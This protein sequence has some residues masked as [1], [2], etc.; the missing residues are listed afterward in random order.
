[1]SLK[2]IQKKLQIIDGKLVL[3]SQAINVASITK[4]F[5]V[6]LVSNQIVLNDATVPS[7]S[8]DEQLLYI[9]G[10]TSLLGLTNVET[11]GFFT[12]SAD[13]PALI[14]IISLPLGWTPE[15][16]FSDIVKNDNFSLFNSISFS[17]ALFILSS[18]D[19]KNSDLNL[20]IEEGLNFIAYTTLDGIFQ[21]L[22][23]LLNISNEIKLEGSIG[24]VIDPNNSNKRLPIFDFTAFTPVQASFG[25]L[26][27]QDISIEFAS[28]A[29]I[30]D[31]ENNGTITQLNLAFLASISG[32]IKIGNIIA[33]ITAAIPLN[34]ESNLEFSTYFEEANIPGLDDIAQLIGGSIQD[35]IPLDLIEIDVIKITNVEICISLQNKEIQYIN[36]E[37]QTTN[38]WIIIPNIF[39]IKN[40]VS[41]WFLFSPTQKK[42]QISG[43]ICGVLEIGS[44]ELQIQADLPLTK[45]RA[46]LVWGQSIKVAKLLQHLIPNL[47]IL[48]S[49]QSLSISQLDLTIQPKYKSY[50]FIAKIDDIWS[51]DLEFTRIGIDSL[52]LSINS[53]PNNFSLLCIGNTTLFNQ[54]CSITIERQISYTNQQIQLSNRWLFKGQIQEISLST[55]VRE[56]F[57][58][59]VD[60]FGLKELIISNLNFEMIHGIEQSYAFQGTLYWDTGISLSENQNIIIQATINIYKIYHQVNQAIKGSIS[61]YISTSIPYFET[62]KL[63]AIYEFSQTHKDL[64]FNLQ[65][66]SLSL[67]FTYTS[68][69]SG[70]TIL[71]LSAASGD[72][73]FGELISSIVSL[74]DPTID[75]FQLDPP[76][77]TL[78]AQ[79]FSLSG[80]SVSL[81]TTKKQFEIEYKNLDLNLGFASIEGIKLIYQQKPTVPGQRSV[82]ITIVGTIL[83]KTYGDENAPSWDA[84]NQPPPA[85]PGRGSTIF[86]LQYLGVGQHV[87]FD[88]ATVAK[89]TTISDVM[90]ALR[91]TIIP[92]ATP[93]EKNQNPLKLARNLQFNPQSGLLIGAQFTI[94][95]TLNMSVIFNDPLLYGVRIVL[96][97]EKAQAFAGLEF[98][99]LYRRISDTIG[100]YHSE[101]VLPTTMRQ[102]EFGAVA[103]TLPIIVI[104]IYTNGDFKL[105]FGFPWNFDFSRSFALSS[106]P[107]TG[108][109]GFYFNKLSAETATNLPTITNGC[110]NPV[111]EFGL[112]LKIGLGKS[113]SKGPLQAEFSITVQGILQGTIAWFNPTDIA[114]PT[115][116]YYRI[117]GGVGIIGRLYGNVDFK[118]IQVTVEVL[119]RATVLFIVEAYQPTQL[120]LAA[121][122]S[123][124]A[125]IKIVFININFSFELK[126]QETFILGSIQPTPWILGQPV[127]P[128]LRAE[129]LAATPAPMAM[130]AM[131]AAVMGILADEIADF[132]LQRPESAR[133]LK[134]T[135]V[136]VWIEAG[137]PIQKRLDLFFQ[138]TVT[139]NTEGISI[140]ALLFIENCITPQSQGP[141]TH[142]QDA[143]ADTKDFDRLIQALLI[144]ALH[145]Y[146]YP[147]SP[148]AE[149]FTFQQVRFLEGELLEDLRKLYDL[150]VKG[151]HDPSAPFNFEQLM[152]FL[153]QNFIFHISDCIQDTSGTIFPMFP[154]LSRA[155]GDQ[156]L[157][158]EN[159]NFTAFENYPSAQSIFMDYFSLLIRGGIQAAIDYL[160]NRDRPDTQLSLGNLLDAL[161]RGGPFNHLA[162]MAS[163]FLLHGSRWSQGNT[164]VPLYAATGQQIPL[165]S[166]DLTAI[167]ALTLSK[168]ETLTEVTF[169]DSRKD[170]DGNRLEIPDSPTLQF[171][172]GNEPHGSDTSHD[173]LTLI[174]QLSTVDISL[175]S[176]VPELMPFYKDVP[177]QFNLQHKTDWTATIAAEDWLAQ[178]APS[179][180][181]NSTVIPI[182]ELPV[183]FQNYLRAKG[184]NGIALTLKQGTT[185]SNR[186]SL[187]TNDISTYTWAT[188]LNLTIQRE[189]DANGNPLPNIYRM[190]GVNAADKNL[191]GALLSHIADRDLATSNLQ[192]YLLES[193]ADDNPHSPNDSDRGLVNKPLNNSL[194]LKT[195]LSTESNPPQP[196]TLQI[197]T[198]N[199]DSIFSAKLSEGKNFL[200]LIWE[201]STVN[202]GG[203]FLN[204]S[205]TGDEQG[206]PPN[207]FVDGRT[208]SLILLIVIPGTSTSNTPI[209]TQTAYPFHNC[210][211]VRNLAINLETETIYAESCETVK[212][213]NI[214]TGHIGFRLEQSPPL[215]PISSSTP[216]PSAA[217]QRQQAEYELRQLYHLLGFELLKDNNSAFEIEKALPIG[218]ANGNSNTPVNENLW[219]Y[220]R[221]IRLYSSQP[222]NTTGL[223]PSADQNPYAGINQ[224]ATVGIEFYWQDIYG[225]RFDT[226]RTPGIPVNYQ[227]FPVRYFDPLLGI[228]QWPSVVA[229]YKFIPI[230]GSASQVS[231]DIELEFNPTVQTLDNIY[232]DSSIYQQVYYQIHQPDVEFI[233]R[234]SIL[235]D[236][237]T[238]IEKQLLINFVTSIY[239][240]LDS[241]KKRLEAGLNTS[242]PPA[243]EA[244]P[245]KL[246][247]SIQLPLFDLTG[248][249]RYPIENPIFPVSV[250]IDI[251]RD[252]DHLG[253]LVYCNNDVPTTAKQVTTY[254][255]PNLSLAT[256]AT[257]EEAED[258]SLRQ[259][260]EAF[261]AAFIRNIDGKGRCGLHLAVGNNPESDPNTPDITN[262]KALWAVHFGKTGI[263]YNINESMPFFFSPAPLSNTLLSGKV[264]LDRYTSGQDL[265]R[266]VEDKQVDSIDLN[267]LA[268]DFLEAVEAF[269]EPAIA[270]PAYN[271]YPEDKDH[272]VTKILKHKQN[273]AEVISKQVT[274]ILEQ[275]DT[276]DISQR[277]N[278]AQET[279][280]QQLLV[281]LV[282]AFDIETIVQYNVDVAVAGNPDWTNDKA[283]CLFGQPVVVSSTR[284]SLPPFTLSSARLPLT[285]LEN[286]SSYLTFLFNTRAP[287]K[288]E[289]LVLTLSYRVHEIEYHLPNL[290][291]SFQESSWLKFILPI[292]NL[293]PSLADSASNPNHIGDVEIPIPLRNYPISPSL[294][295]QRAEIDPDAQAR[296]TDIRQWTYKFTYEHLDI[297]QDAIEGSIH[298][299]VTPPPSNAQDSTIRQQ[300]LFSE[301]VNFS[302]IYPK[303]NADLQQVK[304]YNPQKDEVNIKRAIA[305]LEELIGRVVE[306]WKNWQ[307]DLTKPPSREIQYQISEADNES[308]KEVII[309][310]NNGLPPILT[311]DSVPGYKLTGRKNEAASQ[312]TYEFQKKTLEEA[313]KDPIFGESSIPDRTIAIENLDIIEHQSAW[314][315]IW[316]TRNKDLINSRTT[317]PLF[318]FQTPT[319]RFNN[320]LTPLLRNTTI[321]DI[322]DLALPRKKTLEDHIQKLFEVLLPTNSNQPYDIRIH[323]HYAFALAKARYESDTLLS[324]L[325]VLLSPRISISTNTRQKLESSLV[326]K[327]K[328]W[329]ERFQPNQTK[330]MYLFSISIFSNSV[331]PH[332]STVENLPLLIIERL[333]LHLKDVSLIDSNN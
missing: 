195:N 187:S 129:P 323:C 233:V 83:G 253:D 235:R 292:D 322:A 326:A 24:F 153:Q 33:N 76:W 232:N 269:L 7:L 214:P 180:P 231:L 72:I 136:S 102:M 13:K 103:L 139:R 260:A 239:Q 43:S 100:V 151:T 293:D 41:Q 272:P 327:I 47:P 248:N 94:I 86:E 286:K 181:N 321:W 121:E 35:Y 125:S 300:A 224:G 275:I 261:E 15:I 215:E 108:T 119:V 290:S 104:D 28:V 115:D 209:S 30:D 168:P 137:K 95:G 252:K 31:V 34:S 89:L 23:N 79:K 22:N 45:I 265:E 329:Q 36:F 274:N 247:T 9:S 90:T 138:P 169:T 85:I 202:T 8:E 116:Q 219:I 128:S 284:S 302:I 161:D 107:F 120:S 198:P 69:T 3:D 278:I 152:Q 312:T 242:N 268:H 141:E 250:Q 163:R 57:R 244:N 132:E 281:N 18:A 310:V 49:M 127:T 154:Q 27:L 37:F 92:P 229:S 289:N 39:I 201:A 38:S 258:N 87:S 216:S 333:E 6:I 146:Y 68:S 130:M 208:A 240:R 26:I 67:N 246:T 63:A 14:M 71:T 318:V 273:L 259:F 204:Y 32:T 212:V 254:L 165:Q 295:L 217:E 193:V 53:A 140:I 189:L 44:K 296:L 191:L 110:F 199:S 328:R 294:V 170:A 126:I 249:F 82:N 5:E 331:M 133:P 291:G 305:A 241:I 19:Y 306:A 251:V 162:G 184:R 80:F 56:I 299:N 101:L 149:T 256:D 81:N 174:Q 12:I 283:P 263:D 314:A 150:F 155:I 188:K 307:I 17:N 124:S 267:L 2:D 122:V 230:E 303:I 117:Q 172:L 255:T 196:S 276:T 228:H 262:N 222:D 60:G 210:A 298:Y 211:I 280:R 203:Y 183:T 118:V 197:T 313:A 166:T 304:S 11:R 257:R 227:E 167:F 96:S 65:L 46:W 185:Q 159:L 10:W 316:L 332:A 77:D 319:I 142:N 160:E 186:R 182:L 156:S 135:P 54:P 243:E 194:L 206:I 106:F 134:W 234:N 113:F 245:I 308:G 279:L 324:T 21:P 29:F 176:A 200:Q 317:N 16:S 330:G 114:Q 158:I 237:E 297:A 226:N 84:L 207:L 171:T 111:L 25:N 266:H 178:I 157:P 40:I 177:Q 52:F 66:G 99:I 315:A 320:K 271:L 270:I 93:A 42:R 58:E 4:L 309:A 325:P 88:S 175:P 288:F 301:L 238:V 75:D 1:M 55:L 218:P 61:G 97:G 225:N 64:K 221:V 145:A 148:P 277:L 213:L 285:P 147:T 91:E 62:L 73:T 74:V 143:A 20:E 287:E 179:E 173:L 48:D 264:Q 70:E 282:E 109:G 59:E 144:W 98:E 223:L 220:E 311:K 51:F 190:L 123:V 131:E 236:T 192:L 78:N 112:G 105:D 164:T 50:S 205:C